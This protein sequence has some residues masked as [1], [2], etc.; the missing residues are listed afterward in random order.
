MRVIL[1]GNSF[2]TGGVFTDEINDDR[3]DNAGFVDEGIVGIGFMADGLVYCDCIGI[4]LAGNLFGCYLWQL[5]QPVECSPDRR[6][7]RRVVGPV[8]L[9]GQRIL[10]AAGVAG[11]PAAGGKL[12]G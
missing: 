9:P 2:L 1:A 7:F 6:A 11:G 4:L 10:P 5:E 8:L 12:I 3:F